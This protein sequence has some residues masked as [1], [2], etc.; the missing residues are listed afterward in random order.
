MTR[1]IMFSFLVLTIFV[2]MLT[3]CSTE[4]IMNYD[5]NGNLN[6]I[7]QTT[8]S[9]SVEVIKLYD[10]ESEVLITRNTADKTAVIEIK[11]KIDTT[12]YDF[13]YFKE[14]F[15]EQ[16]LLSLMCG[17]ISRSFFK[18]S[19][20]IEESTRDWENMNVEGEIV[21]T[22]NILE[23]YRIIRMNYFLIDNASND[24]LGDCS[25]TGPDSDDII[26]KVGGKVVD[27][28]DDY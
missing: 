3:S 19:E 16:Q 4:P 1:K 11:G 10:E 20:R 13:D 7:T 6:T 17:M 21:S 23:G 27:Y 26:I 8:T 18:D 28:D 9:S 12:E 14:G 24:V 5:D 2:L 25:I 15:V 22:D